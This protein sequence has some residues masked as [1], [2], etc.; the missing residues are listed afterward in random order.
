MEYKIIVDSG[1]D[2]TKQIEQQIGAVSVPLTMHLGEKNYTDDDNLD[3]PGFMAEMKACK[4][5]VSTAAPAPSIYVDAMK[6]AK[7]AFVVTLSSKLSGSFATAVLSRTL[8]E[9]EGITDI[10]VFDSKSASAGELLIAVK[11]RQLLSNGMNKEQIIKTVNEFIE[12][13][14]TYFVL[15][16]YDNLVKSG[17]MS[18]IASKVIHLLNLRLIMGSDGDGSIKLHAK[19]RGTNQMIDKITAFIGSSNRQ[20]AGENMVI[21]HCNNL[22]LATQISNAVKQQFN[23]KEIFIVPVRGIISVYADDKGIVMAF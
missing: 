21:C 11:I 15:E 20:I 16:K 2:I 12:N 13:M 3:L 7:H 9:E 23:F 22:P 4:E 5:K 8:A 17:R 14:K 19:P 6:A 18:N 1:C 10:H